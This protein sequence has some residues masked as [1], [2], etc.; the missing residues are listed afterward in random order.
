[1]ETKNHLQKF[2]TE[3]NSPQSQALPLA[4]KAQL[5]EG[6]EGGLNIGKLIAAV[7][8]RML[9]VASVATT[10]AAAAVVYGLLSKPV[11]EGKFDLL[12]EP[13]TAENK[14]SISPLNEIKTEQRTINETEIKVLQSPKIM[15]PVAQQVLTQYPNTDLTKLKFERLP[16]TNIIS[17]TYRD[18]NPEKI[19]YVMDLL[20]KAYLVYSLEERRSDVRMGLQF[21]EEQLPKLRQQVES[22][23]ERLQTF[24]QKYD[25]I[26]TEGQGR[27]LTDRLNQIT[28]QRRETQTQLARTR[29]LYNALQQQLQMRSPEA[30]VVTALSEAPRYQALL[31][32]LQQIQTRIAVTAAQ[33]REDSPTVQALRSQEQNLLPLVEQ[34]RRAILGK[35][36]QVSRQLPAFA[37]TNTIRQQQTQ[38]LLEA[39]NQIQTLEAENKA[40]TQADIV[41]RQQVKQFPA[42][43][44]QND[45]LVGQLKIASENLNQFLTKREALRIDLAQKQVPWQLITPPT[46]PE[47]SSL[48]LK[49][50]LML[51][52]VMGLLT[53][54]AVALLI[55]KF[56]NVIHTPEDV[57]DLT[58]LP[59][60]GEIPLKKDASS[61]KAGVTEL[62]KSINPIAK[63]SQQKPQTQQQTMAQFWESLRSLYTNIR[64]L[65]FDKPIRS[66]AVISAA[67]E[68]GKSTVALH[69]AQTA[70]MMGQRVLLVDADLRNPNI[71]KRLGLSNTVGLSN[72]IVNDINFQDVLHRVNCEPVAI[73]NSDRAELSVS[74]TSLEVE[75][76]YVL[77]AGQIPPNPAHLLSSHKMQNLAKQFESAFDLIVYDTSPLLGLA[78]SNLLSAHIDASI[79]VVGMGKAHRSALAKAL[80]S[81]KIVGSP[82]IGAVANGVT[83]SYKS[84]YY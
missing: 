35:N 22:L 79:L 27:Q 82:V 68:E 59:L 83:T 29:A 51:G 48:S 37:S 17:V 72:V 70:A 25:L 66:L 28:Q 53:G 38:Q 21:I 60:L 26:D 19:K 63:S 16:N 18:P 56:S 80:E 30:A 84:A 14:L 46:D 24:R 54:I 32:Q 61:V 10:V 76:L 33:Y 78:D 58:R 9:V 75:S 23:Q 52:A 42:L 12:L 81:L 64:F 1:M 69:L 13:I 8:R 4:S 15:T 65:G 36:I 74:K 31:N 45:D 67:A 47:T 34:E 71:H 77:T 6:D 50:N 44:R 40:L 49:R 39:A 43:A 73:K 7:Q 11:Y 3:S 20:S 55:E 2:L 57:K 5:E 62:V 41:L